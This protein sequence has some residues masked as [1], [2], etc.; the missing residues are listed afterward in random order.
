MQI[1]HIFAL[2]L[3]IIIREKRKKHRYDVL[4]IKVD[5]GL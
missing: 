4:R 5:K 3:K 1:F 2:Y